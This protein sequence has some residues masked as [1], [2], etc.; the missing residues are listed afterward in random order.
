MKSRWNKL[1]AIVPL[2]WTCCADSAEKP[3]GTPS[4]N[5]TS[6][7]S[8]W[9]EVQNALRPP[10][11]PAEWRTNPPPEQVIAEYE[12]NNGVLAGHAADKA[13]SFHEKFPNDARADEARKMEV[14]LLGVA[15]KLGATNRLTDFRAARDKRLND[16]KV[17]PDEKFDLKSEEVIEALDDSSSERP[18]KLTNAEKAARALRD[19]FPTREDASRLLL[20][21]AEAHVAD[22]N[23]DRARTLVTDIE[24]KAPAGTRDETKALLRKIDR[25]GKPIQLKFIDLNGKP[26]DIKD[27]A[28]KVVLLDFWATWCGPCVA[29]LPEVK[30]TYAKFKPKG[31][32]IIGISLDRDKEALTQFTASEKMTWPQYFDGLMWEN[33]LAGEFEITGIPA[34]WL[35]DK[36]G[37]L[38]DLNGRHQFEAKIEKLLAEK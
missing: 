7:E 5:A 33:K 28:G 9:Q 36:K 30:D 18:A 1:L 22:G 19:E 4:T 20:T 26:V 17:T 13:R 37:H 14:Q 34:L 35:V 6:A 16:P 10:P 11:P 2:L 38:R 29:A 32:E 31:F 27:Y 15:V 8:A 24:A 23:F 21:V 3:A 25:V 12:R